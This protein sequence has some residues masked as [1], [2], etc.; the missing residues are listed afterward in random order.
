MGRGDGAACL[1]GGTSIF[2][3]QTFSYLQQGRCNLPPR[4]DYDLRSADFLIP[5]GRDGTSCPLNRAGFLDF[6]YGHYG[7]HSYR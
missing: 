3:P 7:T 6:Y 4:R 5:I 2:D 1:L